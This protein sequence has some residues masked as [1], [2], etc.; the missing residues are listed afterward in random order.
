MVYISIFIMSIVSYILYV[1]YVP[2]MNVLCKKLDSKYCQEVEFVVL[3]IRDYQEAAKQKIDKTITIPFA[4]LKRYAHEIPKKPIHLICANSLERNIG[5][6]FLRR[7]GFQIISCT[8]T[9]KDCMKEV[10][11]A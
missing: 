9:E 6:R 8:L 1:R 7:R 5:T 4:Y 10:I 2:V 3:D 11:S